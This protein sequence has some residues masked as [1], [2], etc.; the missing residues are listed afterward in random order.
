VAF[1]FYGK[2]M[3]LACDTEAI[4]AVE[5]T[6]YS[7]LVSKLKEAV[8]QQQETSDGYAWEVNGDTISL[9][10]A[11]EWVAMERRCCPFLTLQLEAPGQGTSYWIK[12]SGPEGAKAFLVA[13]FG[14]D[15]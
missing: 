1:K 2:A 10:E 7:F 6:R 3:V 14:M 5:R 12:L 15:R 9:P 8:M 4:S 11:A 13:E